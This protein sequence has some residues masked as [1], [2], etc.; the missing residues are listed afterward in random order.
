MDDDQRKELTPASV[1]LNLDEARFL[2][3]YLNNVLSDI[4]PD[5]R[6][7]H[8]HIEDGSRELTVWIVQ[9]P[10]EE[11]E[12]IEWYEGGLEPGS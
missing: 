10:E 5:G 12:I 1:Y 9:N 2:H 8:N 3:D 11:K 4:D 6:G 7:E